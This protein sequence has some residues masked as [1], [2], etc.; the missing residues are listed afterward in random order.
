MIIEAVELPI[1]DED[2][3]WEDLEY[4]K[5]W[6][7]VHSKGTGEA[8]T[9]TSAFVGGL[10]YKVN[11]PTIP[12]KGYGPL[13]VC[14]S[15]GAARSVARINGEEG[16]RNVHLC[17]YKPSTTK[18]VWTG[19]KSTLLCELPDGSALADCVILGRRV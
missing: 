18:W 19:V 16:W 9:F 1:T 17:W 7:V 6:K 13:V 3:W 2:E 14:D 5:G 11:W 4:R 8:V 10:E 12:R 15:E